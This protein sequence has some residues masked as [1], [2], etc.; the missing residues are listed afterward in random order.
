MAPL[1]RGHTPPRVIGR[2]GYEKYRECLRL[3][4][5]YRCAY[6][7]AHEVEVGPSGKF[8]GFE[9]EHFRP[10]GRHEFRRFANTYTNLLW[11][12]HACNRAK[13]FGW[14]TAAEIAKGE[15]FV[16]PSA[17]PLGAFL[18]VAGD[19]VVPN[20]SEPAATYMIEEI[21]LNS[22]LHQRRRKRRRDVATNIATLKASLA[23]FKQRLTPNATPM[24]LAEIA[25]AETSLSELSA[26]TGVRAPWD[27]P[28][29]C[30]CDSA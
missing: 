15:R 25:S 1:H 7:L 19:E 9:I 27:E 20:P 28:E 14:P 8:G 16:D 13:D 5:A 21:H 26:L 23:I 11:A 24:E 22:D 29:W 10:Q 30:H 2:D 12:C 3:D 6:C 17:E 4:F 18:T